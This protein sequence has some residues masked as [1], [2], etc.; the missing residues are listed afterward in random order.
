MP[1][2][3]PRHWLSA[4]GLRTLRAAVRFIGR[5]KMANV[6]DV[7]KYVL[8]QSGQVTTMKLQK[9]VYYSQAWSL[10]WSGRALFDERI[11]GWC[12]GPVVGVLHYD[13]KGWRTIEAPNLSR[14]NSSQLSEPQREII[15][16]VLAFYGRYSPEELSDLTH[17]ESPWLDARK[18]LDPKEHGNVEITPEAMRV[19]YLQRA[20]TQ[21]APA[22]PETLRAIDRGV[23]DARKGRIVSRGSF[24][25]FLE[26]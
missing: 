7:A 11:G 8:E 1:W 24:S 20:G 12:E 4:V 10:A 15:S 16:A 3:A 13:H 9:L 5:R 6:Y 14:G 22:S 17:R 26:D 23:A 25:R 18:G 2:D 21:E 19:F